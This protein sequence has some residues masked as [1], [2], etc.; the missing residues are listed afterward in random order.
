MND[1]SATTKLTKLT[2]LT[3][4]RASL[5]LIFSL[6]DLLTFNITVQ[7]PSGDKPLLYYKL[8]QMYRVIPSV[9]YSEAQGDSRTQSAL[10][11]SSIMIR[12][13]TACSSTGN[14]YLTSGFRAIRCGCLRV[15][16]PEPIALANSGETLSN[17]YNNPIFDVC[18]AF[19]S[20]MFIIQP[21]LGTV[22]CS[23][24]HVDHRLEDRLAIL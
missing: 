12:G 8:V 6:L 9:S 13:R 5:S 16:L 11:S 18:L 23:E 10:E 21:R 24:G 2:K 14:P 17:I 19:E 1:T 3:Y 7:A 15:K 22:R 4:I 20:L